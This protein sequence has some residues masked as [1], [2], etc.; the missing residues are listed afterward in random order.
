MPLPRPGLAWPPVAAAEFA[1]FTT[2]VSLAPRLFLDS[3]DTRVWEAI[4]PLGLFHGITTNPTLLRRSG[5]SCHMEH[6]DALEIGRAH[7]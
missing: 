5:L 4:C 6:L 1:A 3:A 7:V 2:R